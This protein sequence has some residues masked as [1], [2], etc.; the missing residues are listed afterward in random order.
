MDISQNPVCAATPILFCFVLFCYFLYPIFILLLDT[1]TLK[2]SDTQ[3]G[4]SSTCF[5]CLEEGG[6]DIKAERRVRRSDPKRGKKR[7]ERVGVNWG[8]NPRTGLSILAFK[9]HQDIRKS[10]SY[11]MVIGLGPELNKQTVKLNF[12]PFS[13][14][15]LR[16]SGWFQKVATQRAVM[17]PRNNKTAQPWSH[18]PQPIPTATQTRYYLTYLLNMTT[19]ETLSGNDP[20]NH[21]WKMALDSKTLSAPDEWYHTWQ[22]D[23]SRLACG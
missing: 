17:W 1:L 16:R 15:S 21:V 14:L 10:R 23:C 20:S 11:Y 7:F 3:A 12:T 22:R 6:R 13:T 19:T 4:L 5:L 18:T 9:D 8:V 2:W